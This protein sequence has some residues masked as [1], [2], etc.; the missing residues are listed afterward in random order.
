MTEVQRG[1]P[2]LLRGTEPWHPS[3]SGIRGV[4]IVDQ[5]G[6]LVQVNM[7]PAGLLFLG[8]K[9]DTVPLFSQASPSQPSRRNFGDLA[10]GPQTGAWEEGPQELN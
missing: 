5:G 2:W 3:P 4:S 7:A 6:G 10:P 9:A 8:P 1:M